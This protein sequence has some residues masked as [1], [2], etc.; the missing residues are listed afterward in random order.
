V[1]QIK[2]DNSSLQAFKDC[3]ERYRLKYVLGL[4]KREEGIENHDINFGKAIH[5][6]LEAHYKG[7]DYREA[8]TSEYGIQLDIEDKAKTYEHGLLLLDKY[9]EFY[10]EQDKLFEILEVEQPDLIK[11][12]EFD[13]IVK[14]DMVIKQQGCIYVLEHK[15]TKKSLNSWDY[16]GQFEPNSQV[17]AQTYSCMKKY[18]ECSGVIINA[19]QVG[20]R[21]RAYKGEPAG[22]HCSF[23]RQMFNRTKEQC[24]DWYEQHIEWLERLRDNKEFVPNSTWLKN[25]GQCRY[26][27]MKEI[28]N[29]LADEQI[30]EQLYER[31]DNPFSYLETEV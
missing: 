2:F 31:L 4:K 18:G 3:P 21:E 30:I 5:K 11:V 28:C 15:T 10:N 27:N 26:C 9:I 12:G 25:E 13:F 17:T 1:N 7:K 24:G 22:F 8:F 23:Q 14:R 29:S 20:F 16:W 6:G 19:M